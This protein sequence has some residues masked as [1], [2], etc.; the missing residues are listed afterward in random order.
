MLPPA[1]L[2]LFGALAWVRHRQRQGRSG[3]LGGFV[4]LTALLTASGAALA[5]ADRERLLAALQVG[6]MHSVEG[7]LLG[8]GIEELA[9][10]DGLRQRSQRSEWEYFQVSGVGF[11]FRRNGLAAGFRNEARVALRDGDWLRVSYVEDEPGLAS[12]RRI[13][14]LQRRANKGNTAALR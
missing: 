5:W 14:R 8:H 9:R 12:S 4:A 1:L 11:S 13:L 7:P 3:A 10:Y 6:A 2:L